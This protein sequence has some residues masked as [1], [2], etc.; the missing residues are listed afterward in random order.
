MDSSRIEPPTSNSI[1]NNNNNN[2]TTSQFNSTNNN[3]NEEN[4]L[5]I[6]M[7]NVVGGGEIA[8]I[9]DRRAPEGKD[10]DSLIENHLMDTKEKVTQHPMLMVK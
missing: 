6:D 2:N 5:D 10:N 9:E 8:I 3:N 1:P 7:K 4:S